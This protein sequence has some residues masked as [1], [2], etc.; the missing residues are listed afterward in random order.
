MRPSRP[1]VYLV[2]GF[3][4]NVLPRALAGSVGSY[5]EPPFLSEGDGERT[6]PPPLE[7]N[8]SERLDGVSDR[9]SGEEPGPCHLPS[10]R[11]IA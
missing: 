5:S 1:A 11:M 7:Y 3:R 2:R 10:I 8:P 9:L 6:S 4:L